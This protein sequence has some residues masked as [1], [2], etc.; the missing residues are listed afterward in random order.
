LSAGAAGGLA[1]HA[2]SAHE[3]S[4]RAQR[5]EVV[6]CAVTGEP[7]RGDEAAIVG[8]MA[9]GLEA[10]L[11][12]VATCLAGGC[13]ADVVQEDGSGG[14]DGTGGTT[15]CDDHADCPDALCHFAS[16]TCIPACGANEVCPDDLVCDGCATSS[17][18]GCR[19]C[20]AAC[21]P[22]TDPEVCASHDECP[23][24]QV[25][26]FEGS[27]CQYACTVDD[28]CPGEM[29]CQDCLTSSC[30]GCDDCVSACEL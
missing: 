10:A 1:P 11:L 21:V 2:P 15:R 28:D 14:S 27:F 29:Y 23:G 12:L 26:V 9:R 4:A 19:D 24:D 17:C 30:P 5:C 18:A 6:E 13:S 22:P 3:R 7:W 20:Q 25:C 8:V 16:G